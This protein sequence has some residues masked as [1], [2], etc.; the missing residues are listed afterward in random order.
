MITQATKRSYTKHKMTGSKIHDVWKEMCRRCNG[1]S[2]NSISYFKNKIQ[3][4]AEWRKA[5]SFIVWA[6]QNGYKEG[7]VLDRISNTHGYSPENCRWVTP[8][9][10]SNNR[11]NTIFLSYAGISSAL[12]YWADGLGVNAH[13]L[14][15]RKARGWNDE[16]TI[17]TPIQKRGE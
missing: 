15:T 1:T 11:K 16:K 7:L 3:V 4:S 5:S 9:E 8:K 2:K 14:R 10:S 12:V 17:T 6:L 13:T